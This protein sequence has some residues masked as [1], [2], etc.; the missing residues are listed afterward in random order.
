M[1]ITFDQAQQQVWKAI[2]KFVCDAD[3]REFTDACFKAYAQIALKGLEVLEKERKA[4]AE[5]PKEEPSKKR[6]IPKG[7]PELIK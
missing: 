5:T 7:S 4:K 1:E 3:E 6:A 2:R